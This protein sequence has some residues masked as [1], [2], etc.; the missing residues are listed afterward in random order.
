MGEQL[1]RPALV[2]V[3]AD[4]VLAVHGIVVVVRHGR[5]VVERAGLGMER[6]NV[7]RAGGLFHE[8]VV[9]LRGGP[10]LFLGDVR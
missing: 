2:L 6:G 9:G 10:A 8:F 7:G 5:V 1:V 4:M 3:D